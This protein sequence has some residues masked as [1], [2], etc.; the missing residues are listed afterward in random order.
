M[1]TTQFA[2]GKSSYRAPELLAD[3]KSRFNNRVDIWSYACIIYE[4]VTGNK[5]FSGDYAVSQYTSSEAS[6]QSLLSALDT[7]HRMLL[8]SFFVH[9]LLEV[10][11][12]KRPS[13]KRLKRLLEISRFAFYFGIQTVEGSQKAFLGAALDVAASRGRLDI[14]T[15]LLDAGAID[16]TM[17]LGNEEYALSQAVMNG[18]THVMKALIEAGIN[19]SIALL[20]AALRGCVEGVICLVESGVDIHAADDSGRTALHLAVLDGDSEMVRVLVRLGANINAIDKQGETPVSMARRSRDESPNVLRIISA[21]E[22]N[23]GERYNH[24]PS[25]ARD[26]VHTASSSITPCQQVNSL[27]DPD[28]LLPAIDDG[29]MFEEDTTRES[30]RC[31]CSAIDYPFPN[32]DL[33]TGL[34]ICCERCEAWQHGPCVGIYNEQ[35]APDVYYCQECRPDLHIS[36]GRVR[37]YMNYAVGN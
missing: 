7:N 27:G 28:A 19:G 36:K 13:A 8:H 2:R 20:E 17:G 9:G 12:S 15:A 35:E 23:S 31:I 33:D 5:A 30:S 10:D 16:M 37:G 22:I 6:P 11:P 4:I 29:D 24:E 34:M 32:S 18:H 25:I 21:G 14:I 26:G 1:A 3:F